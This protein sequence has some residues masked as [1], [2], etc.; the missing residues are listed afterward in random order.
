MLRKERGGAAM[1]QIPMTYRS[2]LKT[3]RKYRAARK[4]RSRAASLQAHLLLRV[5]RKQ[6][7]AQ[8]KE[9]EGRS[10]TAADTTT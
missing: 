9:R 3:T 10:C 4:E 1:L 2:L 8:G 7:L 6:E 5:T